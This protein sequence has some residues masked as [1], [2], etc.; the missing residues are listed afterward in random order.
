LETSE[1]CKF[2]FATCRPQD[3]FYGEIHWNGKKLLEVQGNYM[4]YVDIGG[5]RYMDL[6]EQEH[7]F[8]PVILFI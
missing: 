3:Q 7:W 2:P 1:K 4:G 6:R 8:F 5:V